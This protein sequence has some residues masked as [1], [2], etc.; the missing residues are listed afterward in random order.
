MSD[1]PKPKLVEFPRPEPTVESWS[2]E[3]CVA[4]FLAD[5]R[6][7]KA[8]PAKILVAF[9][10]EKDD[11]SLVPHRWY[12]GLPRIQ[13]IALLEILKQMAVEEWRQ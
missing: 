2:P 9:F 7:G 10:E 5:I 13:E 12:A 1:D 8:R 6:S 4:E 11:G 3:D